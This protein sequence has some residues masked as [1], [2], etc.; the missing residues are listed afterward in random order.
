ML[1]DY[2]LNH[3][4]TDTIEQLAP[5]AQLPSLTALKL[6]YNT[7]TYTELVLQ[8]T[9]LKEQTPFFIANKAFQE[10]QSKFQ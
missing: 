5:L 10:M 2:D 6:F 1:D 3:K 9:N 4:L 8:K 7:E